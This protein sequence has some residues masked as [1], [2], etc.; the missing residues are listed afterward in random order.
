MNL[1]SVNKVIT[2]IGRL[3]DPR[4]ATEGFLPVCSG[5]PAFD[6]SAPPVRYFPRV[7]PEEAGVS[8]QLLAEMLTELSENRTL[9]LHTVTVLQAGRVICEAAFGAQD[10]NIWKYT[11]SGCKTIVGFA[12]GILIGDG[13]LSYDDKVSELFSDRLNAVTRLRFANITVR[14]LLTMRSGIIFN[15]VE[16]MVEGDWL[17]AWFNS[18]VSNEN[19]FDPKAPKPFAYNSMNTYLLAALVTRKSGMSLTDFLRKRLFGPMG[20]TRFY[21]EKSPDGIEKGGWGLYLLP[22]DF[23]KLGVLCMQDGV[24]EDK[25]LVPADYIRR[26]VTAQTDTP[27]S[28]GTKAVHYS[29]GY[30][31]WVGN[32]P[33]AFLFNGMLGQNVLGFPESGIVVV[34]NAGNGEMFQQSDFYAIVT[35]YLGTSDAVKG[36][37]LPDDRDGD[38]ALASVLLSLREHTAEE[39][40]ALDDAF[41][42]PAPT[43][44]PQPEPEPL[45][46][47]EHGFLT[48]LKVLFRPKKAVP[49][50]S[51]AETLRDSAKTNLP[52]PV[53]SLPAEAYALDGASFRVREGEP[54]QAA[55][56]MPVIFQIMQ[57]NYPKGL[58]RISFAV[59]HNSAGEEQLVCTYAEQ[60]AAYVFSVGF[61]KSRRVCLYFRGEPF[62]CAV[63]GAFTHDEDGHSV[64]RLTVEFLETPCTRTIK[65]FFDA[66]G[67]G[68]MLL[69]QEETPGARFIYENVLAEKQE[70]AAQP[71]IGPALEKIDNDY[72]EYKVRR[73][74]APELHLIRE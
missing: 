72:L 65:L 9:H 67:P 48:W 29:Y 13:V 28:T 70:I 38:Y 35:R 57:S 4:R 39:Q 62:L 63:G 50:A 61:Q 32:A 34:S 33:R 1:S 69:R 47:A 18:G 31:M 10:R 17:R 66:D 60:E 43:P 54:S 6:E 68:T 37:A 41:A 30:Q 73:A 58:E 59:R 55:G 12:I 2:L 44:E 21:W 26:A 25:Q 74:M 15:E 36:G 46:P 42:P 27:A 11:F 5:K 71:V 7:S 19:V 8:P 23:A 20:I 49:S 40:K 16:A 3:A 53:P 24:W 56:L 64:L 52:A 45:P 51:D 22:E 14:D